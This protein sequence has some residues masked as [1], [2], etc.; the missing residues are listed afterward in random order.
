MNIDGV[1]EMLIEQMVKAHLVEKQSDFYRLTE[2]SLLTLE[3]MGKKSAMNILAAVESS[4]QRPLAA[5][6]LPSASGTLVLLWQ[7][8]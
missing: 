7:S 3:R 1:G 4:K 6:V 8:F 5:L 2:E